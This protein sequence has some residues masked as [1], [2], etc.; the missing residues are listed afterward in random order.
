MNPAPRRRDLDRAAR[1]LRL[2]RHVDALAARPSRYDHLSPA[3][4]S[5]LTA[6][7]VA[8]AVGRHV[9]VVVGLAHR[10]AWRSSTATH[11][12][13]YGTGFFAELPAAQLARIDYVRN[14]QYTPVVR[15]SGTPEAGT[16]APLTV[17]FSSAGTTD[18][19][20]DRLSYAWDFD[21]NGT[22]DSRAANPSFTYT[23]RGV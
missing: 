12:L 16:T 11:E 8:L 22:V 6:A 10:D 1:P 14:G 15:A 3:L 4:V 17:Q 2:E 19:N 18:A 23:A 13:E 9:V 20:G 5:A 21:S 7:A